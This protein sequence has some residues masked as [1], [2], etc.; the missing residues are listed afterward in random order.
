ME[1]I[2]K[3][4]HLNRYYCRLMPERT[5][6]RRYNT[7]SYPVPKRRKSNR[8]NWTAVSGG[9]VWG[10]IVVVFSCGNVVAVAVLQQRQRKTGK[11]MERQEVFL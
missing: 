4:C 10:A 2:R 8:H 11:G 7:G 9:V 3:Y 1:K 5:L 6:S